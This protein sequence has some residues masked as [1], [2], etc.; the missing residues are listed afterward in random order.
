MKMIF[1][2]DGD[3]NINEGLTGIDMLSQD[4][5]SNQINV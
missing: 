5:Q 1:L 3:N 2:I 4:V